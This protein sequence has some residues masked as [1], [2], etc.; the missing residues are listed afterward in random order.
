VSEQ[1]IPF[2]DDKT[3]DELQQELIQRFWL[4]QNDEQERTTTKANTE[5]LASPE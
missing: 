1:Q 4:R 5:I 2:D 3:K